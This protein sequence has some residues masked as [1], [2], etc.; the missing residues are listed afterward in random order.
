MPHCLR[1]LMSVV[2]VGCSLNRSL[3]CHCSKLTKDGYVIIISVNLDTP[4][5]QSKTILASSPPLHAFVVDVEGER[6]MLVK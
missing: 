4:V 2:N 5:F 1:L 3:Q 6:W